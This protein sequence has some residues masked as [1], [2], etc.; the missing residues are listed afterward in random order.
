[1]NNIDL[2]LSNYNIRLFYSNIHISTIDAFSNIDLD[3]Q[4]QNLNQSINLNIESWKGRIKN[5]FEKKIFRK[6]T[7]LKKAKERF[8]LDGALYAS[9]TGTGSTIYGIFDK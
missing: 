4:I 3:S 2:D 5:D 6:Y 1:M 9:M 8:Y 7:Q